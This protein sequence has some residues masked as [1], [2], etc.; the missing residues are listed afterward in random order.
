MKLN[1]NK[2]KK[3]IKSGGEVWLSRS[4]Y[5]RVHAIQWNAHTYHNSRRKYGITYVTSA[6]INTSSMQ[7]TPVPPCSEFSS[8][9]TLYAQIT[10]CKYC[11]LEL[12]M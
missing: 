6:T 8:S 2:I 9:D 12:V 1:T 10:I 3:C 4:L 11:A 5:E 7:E